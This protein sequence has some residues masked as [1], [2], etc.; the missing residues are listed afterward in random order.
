M[1]RVNHR[2]SA[3]AAAHFDAGEVR[4]RSVRMVMSWVT[5]R[6]MRMTTTMRMTWINNYH[7]TLS[8][9]HSA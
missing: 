2:W 9:R 6:G 7:L 3:A 4:M 1:R 5:V 8:N